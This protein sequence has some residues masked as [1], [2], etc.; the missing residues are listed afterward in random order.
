LLVNLVLGGLAVQA[1]VVTLN[2]GNSSASV[3]LT[4]GNHGGMNNW[5]V[6]LV[7]QLSQQWFWYRVGNTAQA[8]IDTVGNL[9]F[10]TPNPNVLFSTYHNTQFSIEV[11][12]TLTGGSAGSGSSDINESIR[13]T[14]LTA[15]S[16]D[17]HLYQFS[18]YKLGGITG[19]ATATLQKNG[20]GKFIGAF[21]G[22]SSI[23]FNETVATP[24]GDRGEA[25]LSA[26]TLL[27]ELN[28][29]AYSLN[30]NLSAGPGDVGY[31]L[32]WDN[33]ILAGGG[34]IIGKDK[35]ISPVPEPT[36]LALLSV[37]LVAIG[38]R[39]RSS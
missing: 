14:N 6:D 1:Q 17:F 25:N 32:E 33:S 35:S 24:G 7:N 31:A 10:T 39:R 12:Y 5:T 36:T 34:F 3:D 9:S 8:T 16:L 28:G 26:A 37:G 21:Q 4:V 22:N 18:H 19:G 20:L 11:D 38:W 2:N 13:V 30:D 15:T 23:E 29:P 27:G